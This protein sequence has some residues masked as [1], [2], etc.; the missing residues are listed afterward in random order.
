MKPPLLAAVASRGV[1][2]KQSGSLDAVG[3]QPRKQ[4]NVG[5][6][7]TWKARTC[8]AM[9]LTRR[10]RLLLVGV[11]VLLTAAALMTLI[12]FFT[13]PAMAAGLNDLRP[14]ETR[15]VAVPG[16]GTLWALAAEHAPDRDP[17]DVVAEI[18][19]LN[20]LGTST[21]Q[22]GQRIFVPVSR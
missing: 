4:F 2:E 1:V 21:V 6:P 22:A 5:S 12:G 7:R 16:G 19:E 20:N 10:G 18:V 17:R 3:K 13:A 15:T 11:P 9:S 14:T 8:P